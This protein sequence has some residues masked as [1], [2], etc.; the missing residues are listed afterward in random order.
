MSGMASY[1]LYCSLIVQSA[2][3]KWL[4]PGLP[5]ASFSSL[6]FKIIAN[7][8]FSSLHKKSKNEKHNY[9]TYPLHPVGQSLPIWEILKFF[10]PCVNILLWHWND[11]HSIFLNGVCFYNLVFIYFFIM[12]LGS[13][14]IFLPMRIHCKTQR[15]VRLYKTLEESLRLYYFSFKIWHCLVFVRWS[16]LLFN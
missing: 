8:L 3:W 4:N 5:S 7:C 14:M 15:V 2:V 11:Q 12:N 6:L 9:P 1:Y 16:C 10:I 13:V